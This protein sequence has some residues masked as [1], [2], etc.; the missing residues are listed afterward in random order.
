MK[1]NVTR[2]ADEFKLRV[3]QE[4]MDTEASQQELMLKYNIRGNNCITNWMR[5][6]SLMH[7]G[8]NS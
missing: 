3:V 1:K 2:F 5:K 6:F 7:S 4:Y 8:N